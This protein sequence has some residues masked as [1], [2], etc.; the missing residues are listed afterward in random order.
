[1]TRG[2]TRME[3]GLGLRAGLAIVTV[4]ILF[5]R[6]SRAAQQRG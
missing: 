1:V 4:A 3:M 6:L 2:L 5:V